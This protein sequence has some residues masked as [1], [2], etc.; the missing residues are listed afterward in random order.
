MVLM[1]AIIVL[2][3]F[4]TFF[5]LIFVKLRERNHPVIRIIS[6]WINN[7][8]SN[9]VSQPPVYLDAMDE[10]RSIM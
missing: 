10:K 9:K 6:E 8:K 4:G 1:D 3:V 5:F 2:I 7:K